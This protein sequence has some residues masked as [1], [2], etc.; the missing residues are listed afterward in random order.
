M[1]IITI[2]REFGSGGREVGKRLADELGLAYYDREI[3]EEIAKNTEL[4]QK[5]VEKVLDSGFSMNF[6]YNFNTTLT[7]TAPIVYEATNLFTQQHNVIRQIAEKGDCIIVGRGADAILEDLKPLRLFIYADMKSKIAR[8]QKR[9]EAGEN[10]TDKEMKKKI[11]QIDKRRAITHDIVS[12]YPW[13]D[14]RGY[15]LLVNTTGVEIKEIVPA[16]A[17][18]AR[19]WFNK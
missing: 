19:N 1:K 13:G 16:I 3:V 5:Y 8:C 7:H 6:H 11:N 17:E 9:A 10:F 2:G 15:D 4:D 12:D 18:Y 14:K